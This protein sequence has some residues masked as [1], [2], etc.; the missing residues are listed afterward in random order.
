MAEIILK[1][2]NWYQYENIMVK[3]YCFDNNGVFL[4][5]E[6]LVSF[7]ST[8]SNENDFIEK[9]KNA[10]G[11]F[12]VIINKNSTLWAASDKSMI[13]P[14]FYSFENER[15]IISDN[16]YCLLR[17][18]SKIDVEAEIEFSLSAI[19]L[20]E[21]TLIEGIE[22]IK[23]SFYLK[24]H[25]GI[26]CQNSYYTY[27]IKKEDINTGVY[28]E[29]QFETTLLSVFERIIESVNNRQIAIP[30]SGGY[31]SRLIVGMLKKCGYEN[32][33]CYTVGYIHSPEHIIA[34]KVAKKLGYPYCFINNSEQDIKNYKATTDF[35]NYYKFSGFFCNM[36]WMF[37]Y[38]GINYLIK[39]N[40]VD[41]DAVFIPG[42]TGDYL[43][44]SQ[45]TKCG[46]QNNDSLNEIAKRIYSLMFVFDHKKNKIIENKIQKVIK[47]ESE[48]LP[49][50]I[51]DNFL[52]REKYPKHINN[53]ARIYEFFDHEVRLPFWDNELL[54][55]FKTLDPK[56]KENKLFYKN[57]LR[58]N[59]FESLN[60]NFSTELQ[61]STYEVKAARLKNEIKKILPHFIL[62][63]ITN[64]KD[65]I[66]LKELSEPL[67][68]DLRK[69]GITLKTNIINEI[70]LKWYLLQIKNKKEIT[71]KEF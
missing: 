70:S 15:F 21:K 33:V 61:P 63:N 12:S 53:S 32:V 67:L 58:N 36:F 31:D 29:K 28:L 42:H 49:S 14:L 62:K 8:A 24:Y 65:F 48:K 6:N 10:N 44:G 50:S 60:I 18:D 23:P 41:K 27:T 52:L 45:T 11:I 69:Q 68:I 2:K 38:F 7:F 17:D 56:L 4:E 34:E 30:L 43:A 16:P 22:R 46:V 1:N 37:E 40:F 9:I 5:K 57:F 25:D 26:I 39:N 3:G 47:N 54:D 20:D 64:H 13:Y 35:Q 59:L 66:C 71:K 51:F 19:T 55:F